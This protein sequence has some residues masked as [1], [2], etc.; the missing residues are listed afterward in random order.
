MENI[1]SLE[2]IGGPGFNVA[3]SREQTLEL[4]AQHIP[5]SCKLHF[6][7]SPMKV[8]RAIGQ[9]VY[10][11]S[12]TE[13]LDCVNCVAHVGHC[14]PNVIEA[15]KTSM[16]KM[17]NISVGMTDAAS[18]YVA[19]LKATFPPEIDTFL[20]VSSGSEANDVAIQLAR[21]HTG[22][23][24][25]V[26]V[27]RAFHGGLSVTNNVS[28]KQFTS[29][30][31]CPDWVHVV[32]CPDLYRGIYRETD[33]TAVEKYCKNAREVMER[34]VQKEKRKLA[35]FISEPIIT[36][37]GVIVPPSKWMNSIYKDIRSFGGVAIADEAQSGL[38]RCGT[39]MWSFQMHDNLVPDIITIG[40]PLGNGHPMA[41]VATRSSIASKL[42]N[43]TLG[44]YACDL[45]SAAIGLAV[46]ST[47]RSLSLQMNARTVGEFLREGIRA[48]GHQHQ[49]IGQVRGT[50]LMIGV[51]IVHSQKSR[52]PAP[53][54]A[55]KICYKLLEHFVIVA[56]D[57]IHKNVLIITPPM[58]F[59]WENA[60][61]VTVALDKVLQEIESITVDDDDDELTQPFVDSN[62]LLLSMND[63]VNTSSEVSS[64]DDTNVLHNDFFLPPNTSGFLDDADED[65]G[66][67]TSNSFT[68]MD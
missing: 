26:S 12:G 3:L 14:N 20:F 23:Y 48:L 46:L 32:S 57:G 38:G 64:N 34:A 29:G 50:G 4:R 18:E 53:R 41:C 19:K 65:G 59:T 67:Y 36:V 35:C 40:K 17:G 7:K 27:E 25:V 8:V 42:S 22:G 33:I 10:D 2:D 56:N 24:D 21:L 28:P 60:H 15:A 39:S 11:D 16:L 68:C 37:A 13:Y 49:N 5:K 9:Y 66:Y 31:K 1:I 47:V 30:E 52:K 58:C 54:I 63:I 61:R 45:V 44:I 55:D 43:D 62:R 51:E 6:E